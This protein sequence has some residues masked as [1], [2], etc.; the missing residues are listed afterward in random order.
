MSN[1]RLC[2][3]VWLGLCT[4]AACGSGQF[5]NDFSQEIERDCNETLSC[6]MGGKV[7]SCIVKTG[8]ALDKASPGQQQA[9]LDTVSRCEANRGCFYLTCTQALPAAS[10]YSSIHQVQI[11]FDC[12]QQANCTNSRGPATTAKTTTQCMSDM[13]SMLDTNQQAQVSFDAA[14]TACN[15]RMSCDWVTCRTNAIRQ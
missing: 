14:F 3:W 9:F 13:G 2:G 5:S 10:S 1:W 7:E 11:M 8:N 4:L 12:E 15:G 6:S